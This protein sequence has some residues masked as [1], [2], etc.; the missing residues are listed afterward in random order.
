MSRENTGA[1]GPLR[2]VSEEVREFAFYTV[3]NQWTGLRDLAD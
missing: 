3:R 2:P 1:V